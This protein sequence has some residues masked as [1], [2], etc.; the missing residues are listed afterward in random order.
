MQQ[1]LLF[2]QNQ[3]DGEDEVAETLSAAIFPFFWQCPY[4]PN[5]PL[6]LAEV[7]HAPMPFIVGINTRVYESQA[8][9][10]FDVV[11]FDLDSQTE[12][13]S[14]VRKYLK[15]SILPKKP[16]KRLRATLEQI[17]EQMEDEAKAL[18]RKS[19]LSE[20][21]NKMRRCRKKWNKAMQEAL[22][23]FIGSLMLGYAEHMIPIAETSDEQPSSTTGS[24]FNWQT[25]ILSRDKGAQE[26]YKRFCDTQS[27][28]RFIE[29]RA[30]VS[31]KSVFNVFFDDCIAKL[32]LER[33]M[34]TEIRLVGSSREDSN[35]K[36]PKTDAS[37]V[38]Q[39]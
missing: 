5:C 1:H 12:C 30:F 23:R 14:I 4:I 16:F 32:Q 3:H 28:I 20:A 6:A 31:D 38:A 7:I 34:D 27:F 9:I 24:M 25:F 2:E 15:T 36:I 10:P 26:F 35:P 21:E 39:R 8:E 19:T 33:T 22:L 13:R 18:R 29:E 37:P 11:V 17:E